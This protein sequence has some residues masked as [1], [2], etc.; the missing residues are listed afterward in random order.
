MLC[1]K[2]NWDYTV[3]AARRLQRKP[4]RSCT[5]LNKKMHRHMAQ[6]RGRNTLDRDAEVLTSIVSKSGLLT[7]SGPKIR[8]YFRNFSVNKIAFWD[9]YVC[10][11]TSAQKLFPIFSLELLL[12][13]FT[14]LIFSF[15][16]RS[17]SMSDTLI[18]VITTQ[19]RNDVM[20]KCPNFKQV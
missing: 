12:K 10:K 9:F 14:Y 6:G 2:T 3:P 16:L 20:Q 19:C 4:P 11:Q 8:H 13:I 5:R 7:T 15:E 1:T 17:T 18:V